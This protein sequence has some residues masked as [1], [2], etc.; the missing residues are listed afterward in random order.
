MASSSPTTTTSTERSY[1]EGGDVDF[2]ALAAKDDDFAAVCKVSKDKRWIDF[3][4]PKVVQYARTAHTTFF[5]E[6]DSSVDYS[7]DL[8]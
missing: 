6:N 3:Q 4:D 5:A 1:Y 8:Y 7:P 2:D